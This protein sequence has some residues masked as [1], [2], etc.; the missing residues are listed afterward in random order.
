[1]LNVVCT[2]KKEIA[3][4]GWKEILIQVNKGKKDAI[5]CRIHA[6]YVCCYLMIQ[7]HD[8]P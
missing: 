2:G 7:E 6:D 3:Q 4:D 1:M 8:M 5:A